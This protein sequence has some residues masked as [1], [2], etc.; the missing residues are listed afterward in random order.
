MGQKNQTYFFC[1]QSK[2]DFDKMRSNI[3]HVKYKFYF[4]AAS[5]QA[6][7]PVDNS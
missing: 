4:S 3:I 1:C 7:C 5:L 6:F 2:D